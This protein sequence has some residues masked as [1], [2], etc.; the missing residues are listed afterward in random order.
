M[1]NIQ[2]GVIPFNEIWFHLTDKTNGHINEHKKHEL[3]TDIY[4][5]IYKTPFQGCYGTNLEQ[6]IPKQEM[7]KSRS[8]AFD[9]EK[10]K[11]HLENYTKDKSPTKISCYQKISDA[12]DSNDSNRERP[13]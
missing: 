6:R 12:S 5:S 1:K 8:L 4:G 13:V 7:L 9:I 11:N 3:E 2:D 10:I